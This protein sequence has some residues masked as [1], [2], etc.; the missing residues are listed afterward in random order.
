[1]D[2]DTS[3]KKSLD[4]KFLAHPKQ[5]IGQTLL[6]IISF[7]LIL[8]ALDLF[9]DGIVVA[10][11]GASGFI[12]F[13]G[14]HTRSSQPRFLVGGYLTGIIAA[15]ICHLIIFGFQ[16]V[17]FPFFAQN[18]LAISGA[19]AVGISMFLMVIFNTEH[20]P[21]CALA[22]GLVVDG[23]QP[24]TAMTAFIAI[25]LLS[26]TKRLLKPFMIDLL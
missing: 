24:L 17:Y 4:Q 13:T 7:F 20:P 6:M 26:I 22:L 10:S 21:A 11:L 16:R 14:P 18:G 23:F 5:Y 9:T 1:M 2:G 15:F 3:V 12:A 8:L 25:V 19:L